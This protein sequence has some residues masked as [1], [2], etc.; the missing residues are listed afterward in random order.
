MGT[1]GA[2]G[3]RC[4]QKDK[5]VYNHMSS[6]PKAL[7][8]AMVDWLFFNL[9]DKQEIKNKIRNLTDISG[10]EPTQEQI[11]KL[12]PFTNLGVS[13]GSTKDWYCLLRNTQGDMVAT[14][15]AGFYEDY[16]DFMNDSLFNEWAYI[17]N[18]DE[19]ILEVYKGFQKTPH[20]EGRYQSTVAING[21]YPVKL[22]GTIAFATIDTNLEEALSQM[23]K[24]ES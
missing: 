20:T 3:F 21:Y 23:K 24:M 19:E 11:E 4:N 13:N 17:A 7:G 16:A 18:F 2:F 6:Y 8:V 15:E 12:R 1:R 5:I 10:L 9:R 22:I 14:L